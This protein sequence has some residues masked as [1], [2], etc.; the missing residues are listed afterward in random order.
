MRTLFDPAVCHSHGQ[1]QSFRPRSNSWLLGA[2]RALTSLCSCTALWRPIVSARRNGPLALTIS[3]GEELSLFQNLK[4]KVNGTVKE[5][6]ISVFFNKHLPL[7]HC[8][9]PQIVFAYTRHFELA[10][11]FEFK[12]DSAVSM[13]PLC[14]GARSYT[15]VIFSH[16]AVSTTPLTSDS[17]VPLTPMSFDSTAF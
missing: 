7:G 10:E 3:L 15:K 1:T 13:T 16:S 17:A 12:V 2:A 9:A 14:H 4:L 6:F 8:L 5:F 11:I